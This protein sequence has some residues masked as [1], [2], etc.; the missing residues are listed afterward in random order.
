M[1]P[2]WQGVQ[3]VLEKIKWKLNSWGTS[4]HLEKFVTGLLQTGFRS[5]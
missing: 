2:K 4:E 3:C 1:E 5:L